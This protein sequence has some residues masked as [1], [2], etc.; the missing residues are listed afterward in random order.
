[1]FTETLRKACCGSSHIGENMKSKMKLSLLACA[2]GAASIAN[3]QIA[4]EPSNIPPPS[5]IIR[6]PGNMTT[7]DMPVIVS[8]PREDLG[9]GTT[10]AP[11]N[12]TPRQA[13]PVIRSLGSGSSTGT[14]VNGGTS[15]GAA[16]N[17]N[18]GGT[19]TQAGA[20]T[21]NSIGAP[22]AQS[23]NGSTSSAGNGGPTNIGGV[24][25]ST[26]SAGLNG[27]IVPSSGG[28]AGITDSGSKP[29]DRGAAGAAA[30]TGA[31]G[32]NA[33]TG[34]SNG[35]NTAGTDNGTNAGNNGPSNTLGDQSSPAGATSGTVP[36]G[37]AAIPRTNG[38]TG[39]Q[40]GAASGGK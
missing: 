32:T 35:S 25:G 21:S 33:T 23:V 30:A 7:P 18:G 5:D 3:A 9:R 22:A 26:S 15:G 31:N 40:G 19:A 38:A 36:A 10:T 11:V 13:Q 4:N 8:P 34:L 6:L 37:R 17:T 28:K 16:L 24:N 20:A 39:A 29:S 1:M 2:L 14:T 12:G 27:G